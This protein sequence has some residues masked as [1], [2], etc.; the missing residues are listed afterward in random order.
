VW[1]QWRNLVVGAVL[2][3]VILFGLVWARFWPSQIGVVSA[4]LMHTEQSLGK[5]GWLMAALFQTLIAL[6]GIL[7]ASVGAVTSGLIYGTKLGFLICAPATLVGAIAAFLFSRS[8]FRA[9]ISRILQGRPRLMLLDE[10]VA[11]DGWRL[12]C[13]LRISPIMP[14]AVTSYALGLTSL[15]LLPY[16]VGT[17]ASLPALLL[18]VVMGDLTRVGMASVSAGNAAPMQ[19]VLLAVA[20]LATVLLAL[21]LGNMVRNVLKVAAFPAER[22]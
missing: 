21:R 19:W 12:V 5:A 6:C 13:L 9:S 17:L 2:L 15:K 18:Y 3:S 7:P 16:L 20:L 11:R 1:L 22:K 4:W 14:F 10:A 8:L